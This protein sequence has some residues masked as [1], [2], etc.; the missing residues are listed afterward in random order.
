MSSIGLQIPKPAA[1]LFIMKTWKLS[2]L[3]V[4]A[5]LVG[6]MVPGAI[7]AT[8]LAKINNYTLSLEEFNK[9]YQESLKFFQFRA[10]SR[11]GLLDELIKRELGVQEARKQSLDKDPEVIDRMNTVLYQALLERQL[12]KEFEKIQVSDSEA[13]DFYAKN[14][15][16]RT[17]HIFVAVKP[18]ATPDE[19]KS[20]YD[21]I[22]KIQ[23]TELKSGK[24]TFAEVAQH[25][26]DGVAA[27][28]GGDLDF[29]TKDK[30]DPNYYEAALKLK[31]VGKVS[32]IVR[33]QF[34]YHIIKLTGMKSWDE[35][36]DKAQVK[37]LLIEQRRL[38]I[39]DRYM[40][41]L[42]QQAKI[43]VRSELIKD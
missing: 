27:P 10:P 22:K 23:D 17:S 11:K 15:E 12:T 14:P 42:R 21:R 24:M 18:E 25:S 2:Y 13:K 39:F 3:A 41:Q 30:L 9:K 28:M 40:K 35:V 29:Q 7:A 1:N 34:G 43:I 4:L 31:S 26:S 36:T 16:I 6:L 38:D 37:R 8:E 33:S 5:S 19:E 20:A 32:G